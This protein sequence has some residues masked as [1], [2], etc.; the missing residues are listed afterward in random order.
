MAHSKAR[1]GEPL[2]VL[3]LGQEKLNLLGKVKFIL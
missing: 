3:G 1:L 2:K